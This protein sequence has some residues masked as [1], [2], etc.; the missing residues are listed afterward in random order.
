MDNLKNILNYDPSTGVFTWAVDR[1]GAIKRGN[2]A[3]G[4]DRHGYRRIRTGGTQYACGRVAWFLMKGVWPVSDIDHINQNRSD[5]R[6]SNLRLVTRQENL[7]NA[8]QR[9]NNKSGVVGVDWMLG[10]GKWRA[11]IYVSG[12]W[13]FL[14]YHTNKFEAVC[15]RKTA[16]QKYSF[17]PNHGKMKCL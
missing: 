6:W 5:N 4:I 1:G 3:G 12:K 7:Q 9:K 17:H 16:E 15:A 2:V 14:G 11:C 13:I 8:S 10:T